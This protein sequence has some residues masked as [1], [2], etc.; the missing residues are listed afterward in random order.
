MNSLLIAAVVVLVLGSAFFSSAEI[1]LNSASPHKLRS[2]AESGD[3][4]AI[5][6]QRIEESYTQVLSTVLVG[7]NLVN[8]ATTS[9]ITVLL[10]DAMGAVGQRYA[11]L[12][13]T[14]LLL[15]CG[16]IV[17]K[18]L[19]ADHCNQLVLTYSGPLQFFITLFKPVV[20]LVSKLVGLLSPLWTP[21]EAEPTM[22]DEELVMVVESIQDE[23][24]ITESE[25]ELIKSAIEF[26]DITAHEIMT[27]RVD[28]LAVDVD[29]SLEELF[30]EEDVT[31]YTRIPVYEESVDHIVGIVNISDIL[32]KAL[33]PEGLPGVNLRELMAEPKFVHMTKNISDLLKEMRDEGRNMAVVLDAYGGTAGIVTMEDILEEL[34]G[35]IFDETDEDEEPDYTEMSENEFLFDGDMNIYDV[36]DLLDYEPREFESEYNTLSGWITEMLDRFPEAGDSFTYDRLT[37]TVLSVEDRRVTE[38]RILITPEEEEEK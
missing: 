2:K 4:R 17:P 38:A 5:R 37:V 16:E 7:N 1:V 36:F 29:D 23:G 34:V 21:E 24:V 9:V 14:L 28:L 22:T 18:I 13:T 35:D 25:G 33:E 8:I 3:K 26:A 30:S 15:I 32:K 20:W 31:H 19:A 27:P 6:A 11:E 12:I 10:V